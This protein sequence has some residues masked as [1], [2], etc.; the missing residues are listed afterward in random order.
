LAIGDH[1]CIAVP[2]TKVLLAAYASIAELR[3]TAQSLS[4]AAAT[5]KFHSA[6]KAAIAPYCGTVIEECEDKVVD[7][8]VQPSG[9]HDRTIEYDLGDMLTRMTQHLDPEIMVHWPI[10]EP[11]LHG[12]LKKWTEV[13][14][15]LDQL[16][17]TDRER[18]EL[19]RNGWCYGY[20]SGTV[21]AI[22]IAISPPF[23]F[24]CNMQ[25]LVATDGARCQAHR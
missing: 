17:D 14:G 13:N 16:S 25:L 3:S 12:T 1:E 7:G 20:P 9:P 6:L 5:A 23:L 24:H 10:A 21:R 8:E 4:D 22:V 2:L 18:F 19:F 11:N 15:D